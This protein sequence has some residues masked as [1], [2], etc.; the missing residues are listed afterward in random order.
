[1]NQLNKN[2]NLCEVFPDLKTY[3]V[4]KSKL[5]RSVEIDGLAEINDTLLVVECKYRNI[6]FDKKMWEHLQE[7]VS[8]FP[9]KLKRIYYIFSKSGFTDEV[10]KLQSQTIN[11]IEAKD[12]FN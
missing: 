5:G 10:K 2:G 6:P 3:K 1:M 9:D 12:L 7:S 4:E 8:V 11:L